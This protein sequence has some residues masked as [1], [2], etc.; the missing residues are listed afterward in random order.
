M[1]QLTPFPVPL[2]NVAVNVAARR[3]SLVVAGAWVIPV[4]VAGGSMVTLAVAVRLV[5]ACAI[6]VITTTLLVGGVGGAVYKPFVSIE[7]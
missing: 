1:Y 4:I 2:E 6:A 5:C 7:P 3:R